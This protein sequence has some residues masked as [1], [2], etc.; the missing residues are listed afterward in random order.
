MI[1][2]DPNNMLRIMCAT[3]A[4]QR[5]RQRQ[6]QLL[7][8]A[9]S[10]AKN[11]SGAALRNTYTGGCSF[12]SCRRCLLPPTHARHTPTHIHTHI[13]THTHTHTP[14]THTHTQIPATAADRR[15]PPADRGRAALLLQHAAGGL[16]HPRRLAAD[17]RR[18]VGGDRWLVPAPVSGPGH[19][20]H[21]GRQGPRDAGHDSGLPERLPLQPLL[22]PVRA[23]PCV[24]RS[25]REP[26]AASL[27]AGTDTG[28]RAPLLLL[29]AAGTGTAAGSWVSSCGRG[30]S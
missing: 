10:A 6:H 22:R 27:P 3:R 16:H 20:H 9:A 7:A 28:S 26:D 8:T 12:H 14:P 30:A 4:R 17:V 23:P 15:W 1:T 11:I 21:H 19:V 25:A 13:H 18:D 5:Q 29:V 2:Y 24:P